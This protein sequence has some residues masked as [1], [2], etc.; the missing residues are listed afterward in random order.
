MG[1]TRSSITRSRRT[2]LLELA[3]EIEGHPDNVA[4][5]LMGGLSIVVRDGETV[6]AA[7][8]TLP[9]DLQCVVYI[10]DM[11]M[12]TRAARN[13]L[14]SHV[15]APRC[16][17]QRGQGRAA[18]REPRAGPPGVSAHRYA[19][20]AASAAAPAGV[21]PDEG[22]IRPCTRGRRTWRVPLR[23]GL[24]HHGA[25]ETGRESRVHDRL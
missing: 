8:V 13:V 25:H 20:Q 21:P 9:A 1:R 16:G 22:D 4:P 10:P 7:P 15:F 18:R 2:R 24:L 5:A 3:T 14:E 6:H 11:P 12:E 17:I 19:G 23:R